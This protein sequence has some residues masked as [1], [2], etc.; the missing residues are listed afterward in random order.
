MMKHVGFAL[1]YFCTHASWSTQKKALLSV[2][3]RLLGS[4][5]TQR[6]WIN[7]IPKSQQWSN[8]VA[9]IGETTALAA[10][11]LGLRNVYFP[12]NPGLEVWVNSILEALQV[13]E[14]QKV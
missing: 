12:T 7:Q 1:H 4:I 13:Q 5:H 3:S 11:N 10:K 14:V 6:A 9:C 8:S 2:D